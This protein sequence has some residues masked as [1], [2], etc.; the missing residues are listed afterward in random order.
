[1]VN[2]LLFK[3]C[4]MCSLLTM[5][6]WNASNFCLVVVNPSSSK[7][8]LVILAVSKALAP[9]L[10]LPKPPVTT[11]VALTC[12]GDPPDF[13]D[14]FEG[15]NKEGNMEDLFCCTRLPY[16]SDRENLFKPSAIWGRNVSDVDDNRAGKEKKEE[17]KE[18][19][20]SYSWVEGEKK[21]KKFE[22]KKMKQ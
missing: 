9:R 1:M 17:E 20:I 16:R 18:M 11:L 5:E 14:L 12:P 4:S 3:A 13:F 8:P 2:F 10:G 6:F 22:K 7:K 21:K 15:E 19:S